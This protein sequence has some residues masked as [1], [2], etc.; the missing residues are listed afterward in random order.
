LVSGGSTA[1]PDL[2]VLALGLPLLLIAY[3]KTK[4]KSPFF[5]QKMISYDTIE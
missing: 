4:G 2:V 5:S 1:I 3:V